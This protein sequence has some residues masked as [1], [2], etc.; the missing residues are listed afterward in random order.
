[1]KCGTRSLDRRCAGRGSRA[2]FV[3]L[4]AFAAWTG[5]GNDPE[6]TS[7]RPPIADIETPVAH[8]LLDDVVPAPAGDDS[9]ALYFRAL[10]AYRE[11]VDLVDLRGLFAEQD[12]A[13]LG[14]DMAVAELRN[15]ENEGVSIVLVIDHSN[16]TADGG[17]LEQTKRAIEELI[18]HVESVGWEQNALAV[19]A[20]AKERTEVIPFG[21]GP[22]EARDRLRL[23]EPDPKAFSAALFDGLDHA[24][25]MLRETSGIPRRSMIVLVS[26][27][28]HSLEVRDPDHPER[29]IQPERRITDVAAQSAAEDGR[30]RILIY[31]IGHPIPPWHEKH[32]ALLDDVASGSGGEYLRTR[33]PNELG[34]LLLGLWDDASRSLKAIVPARMDGEPHRLR[35]R[36]GRRASDVRIATYPSHFEIGPGTVFAGFGAIGAAGLV[37]LVLFLRRPGQLVLAAADQSGHSFRLAQGITRIGAAADNDIQLVDASVSDQH[38]V[39]V[40][41][42]RTV[43]VEDQGSAESTFVNGEATQRRALESGDRLRFGTVEARFER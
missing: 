5:C 20:F 8:L 34:G 32:I 7:S 12:G 21:L 33:H 28:R 43:Y 25:T 40:I 17:A 9:V 31:T 18:D 4:I 38:A 35:L 15:A 23:L 13:L 14:D 36:V 3:S 2:V 37:A 22:A 1:M 39:I 11:N 16:V 42:G 6:A 26:D 27:G 19:V 30:G 10:D 29:F 41:N 24:V